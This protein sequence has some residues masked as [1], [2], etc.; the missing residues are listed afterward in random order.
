M[1]QAGMSWMLSPKA[2]FIADNAISNNPLTS[3]ILSVVYCQFYKAT[4]APPK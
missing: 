4:L 2:L 3:L 1:L